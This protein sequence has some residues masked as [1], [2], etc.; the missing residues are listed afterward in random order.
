MFVCVPHLSPSNPG[1]DLQRAC[2]GTGFGFTPPILARVLGCVRLCACCTCTGTP[3]CPVRCIWSGPGFGFTPPILAG[4]LG[5]VC[6]CACS[7][8]SPRF[9]A[10]VCGVCVWVRFLASPCQS[11][12]GCW[13]MCFCVCA[14]PVPGSGLWCVCVG[15][16]FAFTLPILGRVVECVCWCARGTCTPPFLA[17]VW[18]VCV[19]VWVLGLDGGA[20]PL[21]LCV[22]SGFVAP[23]AVVACHLVLC[24]GC[25]R[26]RTPLACLVV[27][28]WCVA[29]H[30]VRFLSLRRSACSS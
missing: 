27:P 10:W 26:R 11:W 19:C 9:L 25:G 23:A 5:C 13:G 30:P 29:P 20:R 28:R 17:R 7:A 21:V 15:S 18:C 1:W 14:V 22:L 4:V 6:L 3:G 12:L 8:W 16:G 24:R 2:L